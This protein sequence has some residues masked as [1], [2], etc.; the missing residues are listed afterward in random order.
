MGCLS[1][2]VLSGCRSLTPY[3]PDDERSWK[4]SPDLVRGDHLQSIVEK[5][6]NE[7]NVPGVSVS[8]ENGAGEFW[9]L[10]IGH[11]N[12]DRT[13]GIEENSQFQIGSATKTFTAVEILLQVEAGK[14]ALDDTLDRWYPEYP[15]SGKITV[16]N[17]LNHTS[18]IEDLFKSPK[19]LLLSSLAPR[20]IWNQDEVIADLARTKLLFEPGSR[21][22][23]SNTN[24]LLLGGILK[25]ITGKDAHVLFEEDFFTPL[26]MT[27]T[28][29]P[30]G[31]SKE[32]SSLV[33]GLD[34]DYLPMGP[35]W[36]K[37]DQTCWTTL[38][39]TSGGMIST[40]D[41]L[42]LFYK[43]L[44]NGD[45]LNERTMADLLDIEQTDREYPEK[46]MTGY[47]YGLASI[48]VGPDKAVGH[49]G[50]IMGYDTTPLYFPLKDLYIVIMTNH[51][52]MES[53]FSLKLCEELLKEF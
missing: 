11:Q 14:L 44:F 51:T 5:Y 24:Y 42:M 45:I 32:V 2:M 29:L 31:E 26:N 21:F 7:Y 6:L 28:C 27:R 34:Y 13:L 52:K 53:D 48:N 36:M 46:S 38:T 19:L 1:A 41:D 18:G 39:Y 25:Q 15:Q 3:F 10:S 16:E 47:K 43:A 20:K 4:G 23:Y 8:I 9:N 37:T 33:S 17:L 30:P 49:R 22:Q 35:T 50:G 12:K 40:P